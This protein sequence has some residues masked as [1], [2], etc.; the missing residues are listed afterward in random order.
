[1]AMTE[2]QAAYAMRKS[3]VITSLEHGMFLGMGAGA[4][5]SDLLSHLGIT[6]ILNV[7][8]D[9]PRSKASAGLEYCCLSVGDF[10]AD[11]GISRVFDTAL[12]FVRPA[13]N[14]G[15]IVLVH[16]ANGSNRSPTVAVA[17]LM[18][19][20][21]WPLATAYA[22]VASRRSVQPLADNRRE[23]LRFELELRGAASME[24]GPGGKLL[25]L[26]LDSGVTPPAGDASAPLEAAAAAASA[27]AASASSSSAATTTALPR[28]ILEA[29]MAGR[30]EEVVGW[31][32]SGDGKLDSR[33][34]KDASPTAVL[35]AKSASCSTAATD[36]P[37]G[38]LPPSASCPLSKLAARC[39]ECRE[40]TL[41]IAASMGGRKALLTHLLGLCGPSA[42][43]ILEMRDADGYTALMWA[44]EQGEL[45]VLV[46]LLKAGALT[47]PLGRQLEASSLPE[48]SPLPE[49]SSLPPDDAGASSSTETAL[50]IA[51]ERGHA[52]VVFAL[53]RAGARTS[54]V[55]GD[56][57]SALECVARQGHAAVA[58][59]L[60]SKHQLSPRDPH[61]LNALI[62]AAMRGHS[63]VVEL[64]LRGGLDADALDGNGLSARSAARIEGGP[65]V[66]ELIDRVASLKVAAGH[67]IT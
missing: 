50:T 21:N 9:V 28:A 59:A 57:A 45:G 30:M 29:A 41:L 51:C 11:A 33:G 62:I 58:K 3:H 56:G 53:V 10:G 38:S 39:P 42:S 14:S 43:V 20:H 67:E 26:A 37:S 15:G 25:P 52:P 32:E 35:E 7:A 47:D 8:D 55:H 34:S 44:A 27:A 12:A 13:I 46:A 22:H 63:A 18:Q 40:M 4:A 61:A 31:L 36:A 49:G 6:H 2:L 16:C 65:D 19:L 5:D 17:L 60:L 66:L 64:L 23:L 54:A 48:A 1:M 24:E